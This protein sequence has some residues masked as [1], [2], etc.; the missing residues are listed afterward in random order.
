M[1]G[2]LVLAAWVATVVI[3]WL[4]GELL[5]AHGWRVR[6]L[7]FRIHYALRPFDMVANARRWWWQAPA[8]S[9]GTGWTPPR[10]PW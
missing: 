10:W 9:R 7:W 1:T 2:L 8:C 6:W 5:C 4:V 3:G